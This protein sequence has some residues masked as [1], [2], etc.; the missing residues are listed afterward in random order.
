MGDKLKLEYQ[1]L[2][3][4]LESLKSSLIRAETTLEQKEEEFKRAKEELKELTTT[5]DIGQIET[6]IAEIDTQLEGFISEA[7]SL[8]DGN[9]NA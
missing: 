3:Q 2:L 5:T 4:E 9:T 7:K 6:L 1:K 8:L